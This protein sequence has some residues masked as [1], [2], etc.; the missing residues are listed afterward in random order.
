MMIGEKAWDYRTSIPL[1]AVFGALIALYFP[2]LQTLFADWG[3]NVIT[4]TAI[5]SRSSPPT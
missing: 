5:S 2:F 1:L 4:R 3:T